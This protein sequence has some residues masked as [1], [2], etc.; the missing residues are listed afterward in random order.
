M[1]VSLLLLAG[2]TEVEEELMHTLAVCIP[3][4][5]VMTWHLQDLKREGVEG[6]TVL[7][8]CLVVPLGKAKYTVK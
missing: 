5:T 7:R 4:K 2:Y 6:S 1:N 8:M 3:V